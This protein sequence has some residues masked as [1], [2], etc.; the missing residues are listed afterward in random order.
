MAANEERKVT[1]AHCEV[2]LDLFSGMPNPS[3][4]LTEGEAGSFVQRVAAL[5]RISARNLAGNLGYRGFIVQCEQGANSRVIR[6][7]KGTVE[8][9]EGTNTVFALDAGH[10]LER[11]LL[12]SGKPY[13]NNDIFQIVERALQ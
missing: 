6:I 5:P 11:W 3:W 8:I 7:Q 4:I 13:F 10:V 12:N 1:P 2:E 9:S